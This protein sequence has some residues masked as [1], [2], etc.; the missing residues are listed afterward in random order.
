VIGLT[1]LC[2]VPGTLRPAENGPTKKFRRAE[3][4][5]FAPSDGAGIFFDDVFSQGVSGPRPV[6]SVASPVGVSPSTVTPGRQPKRSR[7][8]RGPARAAPTSPAA[9]FGGWSRLIS[10]V[11]IE[12]EV[13]AVK[14]RI[15]R[16]IATPARFR[17]QDYKECRLQFTELAMLFGIIEEY[18]GEVRWKSAGPALR[19]AFARCAA[20]CKTGA[21]EV[22]QEARLRQQ[23]LQDAVGGGRVNL[24]AGQPRDN[25]Q[26]VCDRS[27]LMKLL[28]AL[29]QGGLQP[30]TT[31]EGALAQ[32]AQ[33]FAHRVQVVAAIAAVL[34]Q[35]GMPD[36]EDGDY[37]ALAGQ[38][39][40]AAMQATEA[41]KFANYERVRQAVG[42]IGQSC[43]ACH[44]A[45][46]G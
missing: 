26:G 32:N 42:A 29:H 40:Q 33:G 19:E 41:V 28:E 31:N 14:A 35:P 4:P 20:N 45:Y 15:D 11:T 43:T 36:A 3:L 21:D 46:R 30:M 13:K 34:Q 44:E 37:R 38:V 23:D 27:P 6:G 2:L 25:W 5:K 39:Q 1:V 16:A 17:S 24:P 7:A 8:G 22:F 10:A 12:D 9:A 18:D